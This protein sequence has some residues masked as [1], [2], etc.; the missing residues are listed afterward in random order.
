MLTILIAALLL[1]VAYRAIRGGFRQPQS[2]KLNGY[3]IFAC[4]LLLLLALS[5]AA[6]LSPNAM[7][8]PYMLLIRA[9]SY[10]VG[11]F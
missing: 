3:G 4:I 6:E 2:E 9:L 5:Y 11:L 1:Y 7:F 8:S 10:V